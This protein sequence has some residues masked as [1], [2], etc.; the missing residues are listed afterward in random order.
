LAASSRLPIEDVL[1]EIRTALSGAGA[2][3]IHAPPGAGKTT[4]VPPALLGEP[5]LGGQRIVMLEPRRLAARAAAGR[6]AALRNE[7]VGQTAGYRTR[8]DTRVSSR[9]RIEVVT[10]GVLTR[11]MQS[12]PTLDGYGLV[13][14]DEFHERSLQADTGLA[15]TLHTR[16]L[17]RPDLRILVMSATLDGTA[18]ARLLGDAPVV[19]SPGRLFDVDTRYRPPSSTSRHLTID[20]AFVAGAIHASLRDDRGDVLVFLPGA[21]EIARV[22]DAVSSTAHVD[23]IPLHGSLSV[24]DQD[25]AIAPALPGRRKVVLATSIAE[26]SLTIEGIHIVIDSGLARRS[27]FSPRT[28]MARLETLRVSRAAA[29]QRR[30]RAGRTAPGICYRLWSPDENANLQ[31]FATPEILEGDLAPLALELAAAGITDPA[32]LAWLDAP[33]PAAFSQARELLRQ[34]GALDAQHRLT[35]AGRSM[36][37]SGTHPRLAHML[38]RGRAQ[39]AGTLA[40]ELAALLGERD[41]LRSTSQAVGVD[42]RTRLEALRNPREFADADRSV[43]RRVAQQLRRDTRDVP[44]VRQSSNNDQSSIDDVGRLL[45]LAFPDRVAQRRPGPQPRYVLRN[46]TGAVLPEGDPLSQEPYLVIAESDGRNPEARIWL[47]AP[48]TLDDIEQDFGD[49]IDVTDVAEWDE[50]RGV[51]AFRER[52]L[53]ALVLARTSVSDPDPAAVTD[54]VAH[55]IRRRGLGILP[56]TEGAHR[57]VERLRFLRTHDESWPDVSEAVLATSLLEKLHQALH[58]VRSSRDLRKLDVGAALTGLLDWNQRRRLDELA[59]THFEAPTGSRV[60]IDYSDPTA[61]AVS[62]RL[63]ELF[64]TAETPTILSGRV[65][66]TLHLLSPAQRPMQVTRDLPGFWRSSYFDVRKD[67][68]ARYPK[69]S[70]PDDPLAAQPTRR[71]R[72][73][74]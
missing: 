34:L 57:L 5:W 59:P 19:G 38:I 30:G 68:R 21:P 31:A 16:R 44:G 54:A 4:V 64:G 45:G 14:F 66:L 51:Q 63:Q 22:R 55:A 52:R 42:I 50:E 41:P 53:G 23:V 35:P 24:E 40:D 8:L 70:W 12:D 69:H 7:P 28:G 15:L 37:A 61:P 43:L 71:A 11:M 1:D 6:I 73:R 13:I 39:G 20:A 65:A 46:G 18:V 2:A 3:V 60:P 10:E 74:P 33:P 9:T 32:E 26:T 27:R 25:R 47:A 56:W 29:D 36:S 58:Q 62:I 72:P 67:L 48:L 17:V 49:Q